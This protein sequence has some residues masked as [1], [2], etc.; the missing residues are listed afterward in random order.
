LDSPDENI[1]AVAAI[2]LNQFKDNPR[3]AELLAHRL[4]IE[5]SRLVIEMMY[6]SIPDEA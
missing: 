6:Y 5:T 2:L 1:R 4:Q 3:I